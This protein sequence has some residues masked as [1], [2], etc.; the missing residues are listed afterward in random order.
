[1]GS[2]RRCGNGKCAWRLQPDSSGC[3]VISRADYSFAEMSVPI[4]IRGLITK[5]DGTQ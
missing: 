3:P 5:T 1:M 2:L 4:L